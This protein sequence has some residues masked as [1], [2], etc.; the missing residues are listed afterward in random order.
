[1]VKLLRVWLLF[2]FFGAAFGYIE[3]AAVHYLRIHFYPSGFSF[4]NM[5]IDN[6]T[7]II[8]M[9]RELAT[10]A[11]LFSFAALIR[12]RILLKFAG[13]ITVF[14]FWDIFYYV[15]LYLFE[16]WPKSIMD[17]DILF[18]VPVPWY[19]PV[20]APAIISLAGITGALIVF[21][22]AAKNPDYR[23][24]TASRILIAGALASFFLTF[25]VRPP[26]PAVYDWPLF[27]AGIAL[28]AAGFFFLIKEKAA[29]PKREDQT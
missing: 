21:I 7:L 1:M 20:L 23:T 18:L 22:L 28:T 25:I 11:V 6:R 29:R 16:G 14:S 10:L 4:T 15:F 13:F 26:G 19:A 3:G 12:G 8:E 2:L 5:A 27:L 17:W 9:G 24:A